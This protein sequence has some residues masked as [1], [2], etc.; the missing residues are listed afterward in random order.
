MSKNCDWCGNDF[1]ANVSYQIY[2]TSDCRTEATKEKNLIKQ[3]EKR[4]KSRVGKERA[5]GSCN[6]PLSIYND[7]TYCSTCIGD[8]KDLKRFLRNVK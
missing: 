8:K 3:R 4:I 2:C 6:K 5:C 7:D 1:E